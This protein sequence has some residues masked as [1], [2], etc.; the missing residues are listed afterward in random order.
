MW[1]VTIAKKT[2]RKWAGRQP[3]SDVQAARWAIGRSGR[4]A[5]EGTSK[6]GEANPELRSK[7]STERTAVLGLTLGANSSLCHFFPLSCKR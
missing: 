4:P 7:P 1:E 2:L 3:P 5:G 6:V